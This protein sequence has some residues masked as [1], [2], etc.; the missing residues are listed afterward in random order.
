MGM[1]RL[2]RKADAH[3]PPVQARPPE[4]VGAHG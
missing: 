3:A 2:T 4:R 1:G